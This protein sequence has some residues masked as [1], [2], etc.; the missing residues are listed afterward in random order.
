MSKSIMGCNDLFRI[1]TS[2]KCGDSFSGVLCFDTILLCVW[3]CGSWS[4]GLFG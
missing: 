4:I 1:W 3:I 2:F